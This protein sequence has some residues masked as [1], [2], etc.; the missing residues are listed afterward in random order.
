MTDGAGHH[1]GPHTECTLAAYRDADRRLTRIVSAMKSAGVFGETLIVVTGDHGM[2]NQDTSRQGLPSDFSTQLNNNGI[3]HV[4][5]DWHV[6]LLTMDVA[7]NAPAS[8]SEGQSETVTFTVTDDDTGDPI[9]GAVVTIEGEE[10]DV[11]GATG[12]GGQTTLTF[13][14]NGGPLFARVTHD[15]FNERIVPF[16]IKCSELPNAPGNHIVG[17]NGADT[18]EGTSGPDVIC[19]R[20]GGDQISGLGGGDVVLPGRG[21][22]DVSGGAGEDSLRISLGAD[23]MAGGADDDSSTR[24]PGQRRAIRQQRRRHSLRSPG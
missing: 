5:A 3:D 11:S 24:R 15:D 14:P 2:E 17:T 18:L 23:E 7:T 16:Q 21:A 8:F 4:M 12:T 1:Y 22:D 13:T 20:R 10:G 19:A 9:E 6:Y